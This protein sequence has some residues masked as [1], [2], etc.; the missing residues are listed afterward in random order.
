MTLQEM[1]EALEAIKPDRDSVS[2]VHAVYHSIML[3]FY[4]AIERRKP[5]IWNPKDN[6]QGK[7]DEE[8]CGFRGREF[9]RLSELKKKDATEE[10]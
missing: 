5:L 2:I 9:G 10:F 1:Q 3:S 7:Y 4:Q 8:H 6:L